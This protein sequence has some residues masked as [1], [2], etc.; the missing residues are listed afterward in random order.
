MATAKSRSGY[1]AQPR[2]TVIEATRLAEMAFRHCVW[3]ADPEE[4]P[5]Q[6]AE[7]LVGVFEALVADHAE[8]AGYGFLRDGYGR[9][10]AEEAA[11]VPA[12]WRPGWG[13]PGRERPGTIT[14]GK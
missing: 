14:R 4:T 6:F 13:W 9:M 11:K 5:G 2:M 8:L 3:I 10:I 7:G 1:P 12:G